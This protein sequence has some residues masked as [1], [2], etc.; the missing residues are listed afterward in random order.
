MELYP[1]RVSLY[2]TQGR[3]VGQES[4]PKGS[5]HAGGG[6]KAGLGRVRGEGSEAVVTCSR[7]RLGFGPLFLY[8]DARSFSSLGVRGRWQKRKRYW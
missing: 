5:A 4:G 2:C 1:L 8:P 3:W 7:S 6:G